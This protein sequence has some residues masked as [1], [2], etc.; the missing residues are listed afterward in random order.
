MVHASFAQCQAF[1]GVL[2]DRAK[3]KKQ[4]GIAVPKGK[5][6]EQPRNVI[7][8]MDALRRSVASDQAT[9]PLPK[10][11][12]KSIE[13]QREMLLSIPGKKAKEAAARP[14]AKPNARQKKVG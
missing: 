8:L 3:R 2:S 10:K 6:A 5:A 14:G 12:K 11:G 4:A 9:K 1:A 7:N 13:G